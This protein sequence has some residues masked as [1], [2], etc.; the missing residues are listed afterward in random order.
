MRKIL[1]LALL[2]LISLPLVATAQTER[3]AAVV[4]EDAITMS[5]LN[6]RLRMVAISSGLRED[7][8][9][10]KRLVPQV[11]N[12]LIEEQLKIQEAKRLGI[13]VSGESIEKGYE[14]LAAQNKMDVAQFKKTLD[15]NRI[16]TATMDRQIR[17]QIAWNS[18][19]QKSLRP[20]ITVNDTDIDD[21]LNRLK[22]AVGLE[23]YL[24]AEIFLPVESAKDEDQVRQ[25]ADRLVHEIKENK[26][27]FFRVAQQFSKAAG[28]PQ[29][30]MM[31]WIRQDQLPE[32][33]DKALE[34]ME[35][36][37]ISDPVRSLEGYHILLL[38]DKRKM[39]EDTL[40]SPAQIT[41]D[42]GLE[43]LDRLQRRQLLDLKSSAFIEIRL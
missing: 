27:P 1:Y 33:L 22:N 34:T 11:L 43:R 14:E 35:K 41:Q 42:I 6:E 29:G 7:P 2:I 4:N 3:I 18:V 17:A 26:A 39:S 37:Q 20:Q 21:V 19:I 40:P 9:T 25:L 8:E 32:E 10:I 28:A 24:A 12:S 36:G 38:R 30:G 15:Q 23:E 5:D 16:S 13:E 31:G